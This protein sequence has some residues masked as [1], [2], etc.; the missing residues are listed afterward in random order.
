M[1]PH[2]GCSLLP[3]GRE[4]VELRRKRLPIDSANS[5]PASLMLRIGLSVR[6]GCSVRSRAVQQ[7]V[8]SSAH[9]HHRH[10]NLR[11][12][13]PTYLVKVPRA[14]F[15]HRPSRPSV[16]FRPSDIHLPAL[17]HR[18]RGLC[19]AKTTTRS[20]RVPQFSISAFARGG[21]GL[22]RILFEHVPLI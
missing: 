17:I 16:H 19:S 11:G 3:Y 6:T 20:L 2:P 15:D 22:H 7:Y 9:S 18:L 8:P 1:P 4:G 5:T 14:N 13:A 21:A 10:P 12:A